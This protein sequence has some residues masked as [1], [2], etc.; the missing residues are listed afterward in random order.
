MIVI[1]SAQQ[2]KVQIVVRLYR[3]TITS[4]FILFFFLSFSLQFFDLVKVAIF[5]WK[6]FRDNT[7]VVDFC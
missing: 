1:G 2:H 6:D 3:V 7:N 5:L 4:N